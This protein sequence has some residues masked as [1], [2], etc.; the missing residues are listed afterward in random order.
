MEVEI[1]RVCYWWL[2]RNRWHLTAKCVQMVAWN[3]MLG[4]FARCF[5]DMGVIPH[6]SWILADGFF[7]KYICDGWCFPG[8]RVFDQVERSVTRLFESQMELSLESVVKS[9]YFPLHS[10]HQVDACLDL[11]QLAGIV[12]HHW[13]NL[14]LLIGPDNTTGQSFLIGWS[15]MSYEISKSQQV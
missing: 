7:T 15:F 10:I 11:I 2:E 5:A 14:M 1:N 12:G 3:Q 8:R 6:N 4:S 13:D 9:W